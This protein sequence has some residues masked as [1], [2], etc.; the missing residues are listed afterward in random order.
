[1]MQ[2]LNKSTT[3]RKEQVDSD[4]MAALRAWHRVDC[5][6]REALKRNFLSD[7]VLGYEE[8]IL[9][10]IKDSEDDDMLMLHIQDPIHRLLLHGVYEFYNLISVTI[11]IPGDAKMRK[12][13]KIKKKLGSQSL[14][15]QIKLT[16]FLRMAK[17]AAV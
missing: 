15:P 6:T 2:A 16:Q 1:M 11:S 13:T 10:F 7:L 3:K 14:P 12:V 9:T 5:R 8:R 17:D 4:K